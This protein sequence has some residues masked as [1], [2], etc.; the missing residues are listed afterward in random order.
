MGCGVGAATLCLAAR[1]PGCRVTGFDVQRDLV[2]LAGDN[3]ALN[4]LAGRVSVM[5]GDLL[6]PAAAPRARRLRPRHGQPALPRG[7]ARRRR[8]PI[9]APRPRHS[10]A[11]PISP[12]GCA[13]RSPWSAPRAASPSSIAP[14][15]S[16]RC[17]PCSPAG[18]AR[19][20]SFRCGPGN[21]KPA[22]RVIVRARK[23][24]A[25]PTRLLPGLDA[26]SRR[27][28]LHR[29]GRRGAAPR[30]G[31]GALGGGGLTCAPRRTRS[32]RHDRIARGGVRASRGSFQWR[33]I[34]IRSASPS[35]RRSQA[36]RRGR[37]RRTRR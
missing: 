29:R 3:V 5:H 30:R 8:R 33:N 22:K 32:V 37:G 21:G 7:R 4:D 16:R 36:G 1:V 24:I 18:P 11:T 17:S 2:R 14:T 27:W 28:R 12:P 19:S 10:K 35:A 31:A 9:P 25:T 6:E 13:S 23:Q 26:A 20:S 34:G 15:G